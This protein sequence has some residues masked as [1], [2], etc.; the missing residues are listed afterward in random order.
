MRKLVMETLESRSLLSVSPV[1]ALT[2]AIA[3][4]ASVQ[5]VSSEELN[6]NLGEIVSLNVENSFGED[7]SLAPQLLGEATVALLDMWD[8]LE[9]YDGELDEYLEIG[10]NEQDLTASIDLVSHDLLESQN[11]SEDEIFSYEVIDLSEQ[12]NPGDSIL[13]GGSGDSGSSG[14]SGGTGASGGSEGSGGSGGSGTSGGSGGSGGA[15]TSGGSGG[16]GGVIITATLTGGSSFSGGLAFNTEFAVAEGDRF[17]ISLSGGTGAA[18]VVVGYTISGVSIGDLTNVSSLNAT[19]GLD[20]SGNASLEINT[21][22]DNVF[23]YNEVI[24]V[25]LSAPDVGDYSLTNFEFSVTII[26]APE[27]ICPSDEVINEQGGDRNAVTNDHDSF[28]FDSSTYST[29][30]EVYTPGEVLHVDDVTYSIAS[31]SSGFFTGQNHFFTLDSDSGVVSYNPQSQSS[32]NPSN[33]HKYGFGTFTLDASYGG[34]EALKDSMTIQ[35]RWADVDQARTVVENNLPEVIT[36]QNHPSYNNCSVY[37]SSI[38]SAI[39]SLKQTNTNLSYAIDSAQIVSFSLDENANNNHSTTTHFA[40]LI[41]YIGGTEIFYDDGKLVTNSAG[42]PLQY[43][44]I[45]D[46][47]YWAHL[48]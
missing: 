32:S 6:V 4:D 44:T 5:L 19:V 20:S 42:D 47:P 18:G 17:V 48:N 26:D 14:G 21:L 33:N 13:S 36:D 30:G 15:G 10:D 37:A 35:V 40:Y 45:N 24:T 29:T 9:T 3:E 22:K 12:L 8:S 39:N 28:T 1:N 2:V 38:Q 43:Y 34:L 25:T 41:K 11:D 23:E 31:A 46:V 27:F 7:S 16:S